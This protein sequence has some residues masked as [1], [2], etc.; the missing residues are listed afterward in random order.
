MHFSP[1]YVCYK[2]PPP[3]LPHPTISFSLILSQEKSLVIKPPL[4]TVFS[5]IIFIPLSWAQMSSSAAPCAQEP[6]PVLFL[7]YQTIQQ[8]YLITL[9]LTT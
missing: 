3:T 1:P 4:F 5:M 9:T 2:K 6:R 8:Y 7:Y